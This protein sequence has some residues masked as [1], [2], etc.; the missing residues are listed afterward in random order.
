MKIYVDNVEVYAT[1][2]SANT[3][4][5][6]QSL[7]M[8]AGSRFLVVQSWNSVGAVAK[9]SMF[10]NVTSGTTSA[11]PKS[12]VDMT[13]TICA[14]QNGATVTSPVRVL[15][16]SY[17]TN[18]VTHTKVYV[19]NQE[20][21]AIDADAVDTSLPMA[22]GSHWLVVQSWDSGGRVFSRGHTISVS[23]GTA[24]SCDPGTVNNTVTICQPT[25]AA[26][27]SSPFRLLAAAKSS[28]PVTYMRVYVDGGAIAFEGALS[29]I[30]TSISLGA[31]AHNL[32]VVAWNSLGESFSA[33]R[34]ISVSGGCALPGT[35][36]TV[37]ICSPAAGATVPNPIRVTARAR[38]DSAAI[39]AFRIYVDNQEVFTQTTGNGGSLDKEI[40]VAGGNHSLVVVAWNAS[41][42]AIN[43]G[44]RSFTVPAGI[45]SVK[46]I[47][48]MYQENRSFDQY[49]GQLNA[50]RQRNGIPGT[51][52]GL[53]AN[54]SN[55]SD[56]GASQVSAYELNTVCHENVSPAWNESHLQANRDA[57][58]SNT[59]L[60]NGFVYTAASFA[61]AET[62]AGRTYS[63]VNGLRAMGYYDD[64][65][66][67]YY[68]FMA[69][70][71]AT[72][73]RWFSPAPT[74]SAPNRYYGFAATSAGHAYAA[75]SPL[76]VKTIFDLLEAAGVTWK[77]YY[78]D[79]DAA[80]APA[81]W[82]NSFANF[83]NK[84]GS[85]VV[86][87]SQ[88]FADAAAG[89]LP[90]VAW[91]E[92]GYVSGKDE[93]PGNNIQIGASHVKS[94]LDALLQG[95]AWRDSVFIMT[96][97][98][99]GGIYDHVP[100]AAAVS[101]DGIAPI[102]LQ[103]GDVGGNFDRTGF[104]VPLLVVSPF[105]KKNYVSHTVADF[106]ATLRFIER[107]HALPSLTNRDAAQMDMTEFFDFANPPWLTPPAS[108]PA[109]PTT[110][111]CYFDRLP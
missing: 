1:D 50:Y 3:F 74:R 103:P 5:V 13:V 14:P 56:D 88:Y 42:Q 75:P 33:S 45:E 61:R 93:H 104:R 111:A 23:D 95:A 58:S 90:A 65:A 36:L 38:S 28:S 31:G 22:L 51:V 97:D 40:V 80:G 73:D 98:E 54:A 102:D 27:V 67:P 78:T 2:A 68:Y 96:F 81:T 89:T 46:H 26:T 18:P 17:S 53:P 7:T 19:D 29:K 8:P 84:Y 59:F 106:T 91:V 87:L 41:G 15:A 21:Y 107:R 32:V 44:S 49:F 55:P 82:G 62:A 77:V 37:I 4:T 25:E 94:V 66:L 47:I 30:D 109:Q 101:P 100:P 92:S 52:D 86:P 110:G 16:S 9:A 69:S 63:D 70:N 79:V 6:D 108:I 39:T 72:S 12:S 11:C 64:T 20:V 76:N 48:I 60:M 10:V 83:A 24:Q 57:P 85:K 35:D 43:S 34:N 105:A 99:A 71:F